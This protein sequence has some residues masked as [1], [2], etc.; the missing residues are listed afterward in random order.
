MFFGD[1]DAGKVVTDP[2]RMDDVAGPASFLL[3]RDTSQA[4]REA[5]FRLGEHTWAS[6][7]D[8]IRHG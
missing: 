6:A 4:R 5:G 1:P 8:L 7:T 2:S 3:V